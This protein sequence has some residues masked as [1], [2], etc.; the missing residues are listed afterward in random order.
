[1]FVMKDMKYYLY[2]RIKYVI[3]NKIDF[4]QLDFSY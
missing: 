3:E 4:K 2:E 1:M